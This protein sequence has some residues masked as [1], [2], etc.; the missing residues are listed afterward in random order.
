MKQLRVITT[1]FSFFVFVLSVN[2]V[3]FAASSP[4]TNSDNILIKDNSETGKMQKVTNSICVAV[5]VTA[6]YAKIA[7][8]FD[9][10][11]ALVSDS[12]GTMLNANY[13]GCLSVS[14]MGADVRI[15]PVFDATGAL[16]SDPTGTML[17]ALDSE[18][19][20]IPVTDV[21]TKIA[22]GFDATGKVVSDPT[23]TLSTI[24]P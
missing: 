2:F 10:T 12:T 18:N 1:L 15:S 20:I 13:S 11:G 9:S 6:E 17:N 19:R 3:A 8:V 4:E 5:P 14:A 7:P 22:P 24:N 16:V 23:G 21:N